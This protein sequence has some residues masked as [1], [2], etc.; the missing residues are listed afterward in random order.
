MGNQNMMYITRSIV[1]TFHK[2]QVNALELD[3]FKVELRY[4]ENI[5]YLDDHFEKHFT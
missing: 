3:T 1:L 5:R 2:I 4:Y